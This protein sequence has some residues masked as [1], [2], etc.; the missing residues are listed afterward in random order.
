MRLCSIA[1]GS[2][3][4]CI[5]VGSDRT[6]LLVDTGISKKRVEE[7]LKA[8][9]IADF[10]HVRVRIRVVADGVAFLCHAFY[11]LR[12]RFKI[13]ADKEECCLYAVLFE[14]VQNDQILA[15]G[16]GRAAG[17]GDDVEARL[18]QIDHIEQRSHA[19]G[20]IIAQRRRDI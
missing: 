17:L 3:G 18:F 20:N 13:I 12:L 11:K 4:N 16:F 10:R 6:H 14:R 1:S 5:Y 7:G 15:H 2:S 8:L 19:L 9:D